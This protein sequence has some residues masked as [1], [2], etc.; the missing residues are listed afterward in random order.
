MCRFSCPMVHLV[1]LDNILLVHLV[2]LDNILPF[3]CL[4]AILCV[5]VT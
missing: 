1:V 4:F 3:G 5:F 2:V